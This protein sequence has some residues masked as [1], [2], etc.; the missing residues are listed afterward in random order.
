MLFLLFSIQSTGK[1]GRR[2]GGAGRDVSARKKVRTEPTDSEGSLF[3]IVKSGKTALSVRML[4]E[5]LSHLLKV[6]NMAFSVSTALK[7]VLDRP[8][9]GPGWTCPGTLF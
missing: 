7:P 2:G 9:T 5:L 8:L 1:R 6:T 3:E 4:Y